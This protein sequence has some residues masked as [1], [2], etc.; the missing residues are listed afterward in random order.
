MTIASLEGSIADFPMLEIIQIIAMGEKTGKLVLNGE[1]E[2]LAIYFIAGEAVY[3]QPI[4]YREKI[5]NTL[6]G[7]GHIS[8]ETVNAALNLQHLYSQKGSNKRLGTILVELG[9]VPRTALEEFLKR[10]IE[11]AIYAILS[12]KNGDFYF[13]NEFDLSEDDILLPMVV[14]K[15]VQNGKRLVEERKRIKRSV[16]PLGTVYR[17]GD[18]SDIDLESKLGYQEWKIISLVDGKRTIREIID[19]SGQPPFGVI[20][21]LLMFED[22]GLIIC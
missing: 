2:Q 6:V 8:Q 9:L 12:E 3:A 13:D 10:Q 4:H 15:I 7:K 17:K 1:I 19:C 22:S 20:R 14:E 18:N 21:I 5:G 11:D 16:P